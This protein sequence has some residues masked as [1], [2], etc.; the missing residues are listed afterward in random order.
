[1]QSRE[2]STCYVTKP[3]TLEYFA[4]GRESKLG[5]RTQCK[6]CHREY[7][8]TWYRK[9][10]KE[11]R[12]AREL[13]TT[14]VRGGGLYTIKEVS[15]EEQKARLSRAYEQIYRNAFNASLDPE[16]LQRIVNDDT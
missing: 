7:Y 11:S 5:F 14:M 13:G 2:C 10:G 15:T 1:M 9:N 6:D 16:R 8:K 4:K 12:L 3:L